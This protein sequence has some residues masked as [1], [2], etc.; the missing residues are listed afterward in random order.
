[1]TRLLGCLVLWLA[2]TLCAHGVLAHAVLLESTPANNA[3]LAEAPREIT[4]RFNEPVAPVSLTLTGHAGQAIIPRDAIASHDL[5]LHAALPEAMHPGSYILSYRVVSADSHPISGSFLFAIGAPSNLAPQQPDL[6]DRETIWALL[7]MANRLVLLASLLVSGGGMLFIALVLDGK[8]AAIPGLRRRLRIGALIAMA[9]AG[10][11]VA[12]HGGLLTAADLNAAATWR[13][14]TILTVG[15][16]SSVGTS[17]ALIAFGMGVMVLC[18]RR[19]GQ[20]RRSIWLG[21]CGAIVAATALAASGHAA[22][23]EPRW[24]AA[25]AMA[26]HGLAIAFWLGSLWPLLQ[27]LQQPR[28]VIATAVERFS[29]W[30]VGAVTLLIV[31]GLTMATLQL[32]GDVTALVTT[33]YGRLLTLKLAMVAAVL[34]LASYNKFRLTPMLRRGEDRAVQRLAGTIRWEIFAIGLILTLSIWLGQTPPPNAQVPVERDSPARRAHH[35]AQPRR[36]GATSNPG[37]CRSR[38]R[39]SCQGRTQH[40]QRRPDGSAGS[41]FDRLGIES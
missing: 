18:L 7:V 35:R 3:V 29:H 2:V 11:A 15:W 8:T 32:G 37:L 17:A 1:M 36:H 21:T 38:D 14:G 34:A 25:P 22:T 30:A 4:L 16:R 5:T 27:L 24:L 9:S 28:L 6:R 26:A 40:D 20:Q 41:A 10:L 23:A 39:E 33:P 31:S 13:D 12:L 19:S